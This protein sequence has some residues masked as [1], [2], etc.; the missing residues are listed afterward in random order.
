MVFLAPHEA[1]DTCIFLTYTVLVIYKLEYKYIKCT[2]T[3]KK[4]QVF[5][6]ISNNFIR[7]AY[8]R[9]IYFCTL[10]TYNS[11]CTIF[12]RARESNSQ[13]LLKT[14]HLYFSIVIV[15]LIILNRPFF[16]RQNVSM[17]S[18]VSSVINVMV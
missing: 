2:V 3:K 10:R 14:N 1:L 9:L 4:Q 11:E 5:L 7:T 15:K 17:T 13:R 8:V 16:V 12:I 6:L 18:S